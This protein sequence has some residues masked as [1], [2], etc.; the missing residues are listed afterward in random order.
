MRRVQFIRETNETA[1]FISNQSAQSED[2]A[3]AYYVGTHRY[4]SYTHII[5]M[6]PYMYLGYGTKS[7]RM[8]RLTTFGIRLMF[9]SLG[10]AACAAGWKES[11]ECGTLRDPTIHH[12][13]LVKAFRV[14]MI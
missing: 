7:F 11:D 2:Y 1:G 3:L 9:V 8:S 5:M 13:Y 12:K 4:P 10:R 6:R 14:Q